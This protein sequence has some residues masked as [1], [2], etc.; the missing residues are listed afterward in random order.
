MKV[1]FPFQGRLGIRFSKD[2]VVEEIE[3][4]GLAATKPEMQCGMVLTQVSGRGVDTLD[5]ANFYF[6]EAR[7][8]L[9][10]VF[11]PAPAGSH[12]ASVGSQGSGS[13]SGGGGMR[14]RADSGGGHGNRVE[15]TFPEQG[16]LGIKFSGDLMVENL[17][18]DG[19]AAG[20]PE[21]RPGMVLTHVAGREVESLQDAHVLFVAA[22]WPLT[23]LFKG[24]AGGGG[25]APRARLHDEADADLVLTA[26]PPATASAHGTHT[27]LAPIVDDC[28][29][30]LI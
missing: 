28:V 13:G 12:S 4:G 11:K 18:E 8:P 14:G 20:R 9:K 6:R 22:S 27:A 30:D 29:D 10:L 3:D 19:L 25:Q 26:R 24:A 21:L 15:V 23:L 2:L 5:D 17:A 1:V 7:W 16:R